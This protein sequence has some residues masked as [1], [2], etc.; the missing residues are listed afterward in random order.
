MN[1]HDVI[2]RPVLSE[3]AL[4]GVEA[5]KYVFYVHPSANRTQVKDAVELVF[6]VDVVKLNLANVRGK[7]KTMGRFRGV[8]P[9]RKKATVTLRPGQR[10]QQLEGLT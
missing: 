10:I 7:E 2:L 1:P 8:R 9:Q 5:S 3:K 4:T 6:G